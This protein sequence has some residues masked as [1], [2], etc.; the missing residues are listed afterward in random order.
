M[1]SVQSGL[2][3]WLRI[4]QH[5][6][7]ETTQSLQMKWCLEGCVYSLLLKKY[8]GAVLLLNQALFI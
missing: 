3:W 6:S 4:F 2:F 5:T 7:V 1:V 8:D